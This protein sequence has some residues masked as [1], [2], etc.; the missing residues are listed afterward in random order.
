MTLKDY[1]KMLL[2]AKLN[3]YTDHKN[4]T[5]RTFSV[6]QILRWKIYLDEYNLELWY[7]EGKKNFLADCF[8][9]LPRMENPSV[10]DSAD[11]IEANSANRTKQMLSESN[12]STTNKRL[13]I[14]R[15]K[16]KKERGTLIDFNSIEVPKDNEEIL[17]NEN[18]YL[19]TI[20]P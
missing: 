14:L 18:F 9:R 17:D 12:W 2:G 7:I 19:N 5:F 8:S 6:Q 13:G 1:R 20:D 3:I 16:G 11:Q 10:G 15:K 4:L